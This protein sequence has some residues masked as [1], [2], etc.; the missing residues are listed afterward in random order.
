[1]ANELADKVRELRENL[2]NLDRLRAQLQRELDEIIEATGVVQPQRR[3]RPRKAKA[4]SAPTVIRPGTA[5]YWAAKVLRHRGIPVYIDDLVREIRELS[6][7]TVQKPSL[8]ASLSRHVAA[9][10]PISRPAEGY[11]ALV[12]PEAMFEISDSGEPVR[13]TAIRKR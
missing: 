1:M 10:G 8:V 9:G 2:Q 4:P 7:V 3:G 6:G 12:E 11:Y 5:V 13:T